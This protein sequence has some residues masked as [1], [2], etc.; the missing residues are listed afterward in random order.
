MEYII[1]LENF[2]G[3]FDLLLELIKKREMDIYD[4]H[5]SQITKDFMDSL[6]EMKNKNIDVT[7]DFMEMAS[8]LL[9]IKAKMLIPVEVAKDDPRSELVKQL[10]EYQE[11]KD[12]VEQLKILREFEQK[13]YK[14]QKK[15][16][17]KKEKNGSIQDIIN[18]YKNIF[19][20]KFKVGKNKPFDALAEELT[21]F[22]FTIEDRMEHLKSIIESD[23]KID[24]ESYFTNVES[25]EEMVV[26]FGALLELVKMQFID[27]TIEDDEKVFIIRKGEE[28]HG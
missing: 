1:K 16:V 21:K 24:V 20:K 23:G 18:S 15:E 11:Y 27:I 8:T 12:T 7:S 25:K 26:T 2:E 19:A 6:E 10:L 14:R 3:P 9:S 13:F 4:L 5:I 22:K 28:I 17:V